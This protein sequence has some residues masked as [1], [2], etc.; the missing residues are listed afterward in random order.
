M[1]YS[2]SGYPSWKWEFEF[3]FNVIT[4]GSINEPRILEIGAGDGGFLGRLTGHITCANNVVAI[5]Y[6]DF[7]RSKIENLGV[8]CFSKDVRDLSPLELGGEF[9]YICL[10]QVLEHLDKIDDLLK[11]LDSLLKN[12]GEIIIAVPNEK[13]IEFNELNDALLDMP[14]NHI[15]RWNIMAF[16][17]YAKRNNFVVLQHQCEPANII[18]EMAQFMKYRLLKKSQNVNTLS[19]FF[20]Y[21]NKGVV[22][23]M[24]L[25]LLILIDAIGNFGILF[26]MANNI[27]NRGGMSQIV[28]LNRIE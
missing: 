9:D 15:G 19:H 26:R 1:A 27:K 2:R 18:S 21:G 8:R 4:N 24:G 13:R 17:R 10:F 11:S 14:P 25:A 22:R 5:E 20:L 3:A 23:L 16:Q 6:S 7:G 12:T 28:R